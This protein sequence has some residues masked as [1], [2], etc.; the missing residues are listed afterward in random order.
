MR[1]RAQAPSRHTR[2]P[3]AASRSSPRQPRAD[4]HHALAAVR[5]RARRAAS[6]PRAS[7]P[8]R[9][10]RWREHL[11]VELVRLRAIAKIKGTK[12]DAAY[13]LR[14]RNGGWL[15]TVRLEDSRVP[16]R[17]CLPRGPRPGKFPRFVESRRQRRSGNLHLGEGPY[18]V[19]GE[20]WATMRLFFGGASFFFISF[21]FA[22]TWLIFVLLKS[23]AS[24][25]R[26]AKL[27]SSAGSPSVKQRRIGT[28]QAEIAQNHRKNSKTGAFR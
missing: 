3:S 5:R 27:S 14:A 19:Q 11:A 24:P 20:G 9:P 1:S 8:R 25:A 18:V 10:P 7:A 13:R 22:C 12:R 16:G 28:E 23:P 2:P 17:P 15:E 4:R 6:C 21:F 26:K